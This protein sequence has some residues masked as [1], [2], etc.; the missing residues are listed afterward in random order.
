[1]VT[2]MLT[3]AVSDLVR[4]FFNSAS[5]CWIWAFEVSEAFCKAAS[6][7][8]SFRISSSRAAALSSASAETCAGE[9][10][11]VPFAS[12][13]SSFSSVILRDSQCTR[14]IK[15]AYVYHTR[16]KEEPKLSW[17]N[18]NVPLI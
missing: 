18:K 15:K 11:E 3:N 14:L 12:G 10:S 5:R 2:I 8:R 4:S 16:R 17:K 1:M 13:T 6:S 9:G 7:S